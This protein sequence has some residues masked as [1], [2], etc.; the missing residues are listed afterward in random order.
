MRVLLA[1]Q[2]PAVVARA[3][4]ALLLLAD[5]EVVEVSDPTAAQRL[6][7]DETFDVLIL[8]GDLAPKGGFALLYEIRADGDL[9]GDETPPAV[10]LVTRTQDSFLAEWSRADA[11]VT[12]PVDP[13]ALAGVVGELIGGS[14]AV[15]GPD[16]TEP[17][18]SQS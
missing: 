7:R 15:A 17:A 6:V 18:E 14:L 12:K 8:D 5:V 3:S 1:C 4:S 16:S 13:F 11:T 2:Q 9:R 10:I